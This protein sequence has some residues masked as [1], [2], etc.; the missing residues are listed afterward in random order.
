[1]LHVSADPRKFEDFKRSL[2]KARDA[3]PHLD[4][5]ELV[6]IAQ[7]AAWAKEPRFHLKKGGST[8]TPPPELDHW[9]QRGILDVGPAAAARYKKKLKLQPV[10]PKGSGEKK[11]CGKPKGECKCADGE[12][13]ITDVASKVVSW[14]APKSISGKAQRFLDQ[15]KTWSIV[16]GTVCREPVYRVIEKIVRKLSSA[17]LPFDKIYHLFLVL[18]LKSPEGKQ[19]KLRLERNQT[20]EVSLAKSSDT[21]RTTVTVPDGVTGDACAR[22]IV[23]AGRNISLAEAMK[24]FEVE[25]KRRNPQLG[26][27]R[28]AALPQ[29][30][31]PGNN[32]QD[33]CVSFLKGI[34]LL[35]PSLQNFIKQDVKNL[36]PENVSKGQQ[37]ITDIAGAVSQHLGRGDDPA[38]ADP[39]PP[40]EAITKARAPPPEPA[41]KKAM[42]EYILA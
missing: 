5:E 15:Y 10:P 14:F 13:I 35:T 29:G 6:K 31:I 33:F 7:K 27:W 2:I 17:D 18:T 38:E 19:V 21:D 22:I 42:M 37:A 4:K 11:T 23:P 34:G 25:A 8:W 26:A 9:A 1:M 20:F 30:N 41:A 40:Q 3:Y 39:G 28:Y 12:G 24:N 32:C 36:L 16:G